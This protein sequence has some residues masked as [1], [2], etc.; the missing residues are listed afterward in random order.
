[1]PRSEDSAHVN[2]ERLVY[3]AYPSDVSKGHIL[4]KL[5]GQA[6]TGHAGKLFGHDVCRDDPVLG[7][8]GIVDSK[9]KS[10]L[11]KVSLRKGVKVGALLGSQTLMNLG[12][13]RPEAEGVLNMK[14]IIVTIVQC[15]HG[16]GFSIIQIK[17]HTAT[18]QDAEDTSESSFNPPSFFG[19]R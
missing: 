4:T 13:D 6:P 14:P 8:S 1:M 2:T 17:G 19:F 15:F 3:W 12:W 9:A 11:L 10:T 18:D 16:F 7:V 5:K